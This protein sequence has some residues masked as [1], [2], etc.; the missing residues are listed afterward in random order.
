M[1]F[2]TLLFSCLALSGF[3]QLTNWY[4]EE[5][6][7]NGYFSISTDKAYSELLRG[8]TPKEVIVA[9]IDS[10]IDADHEDL[11]DVMWVN[12][13]EI[14]GNGTD[15]DGN[16]YIDDMH[17]WNFLGNAEGENVNQDTYEMTRL[18]AQYREKYGEMTSDS[19][20]SEKEKK[21]FGQYKEW[22]EKIKKE[23]SNA[24]SKL[25]EFDRTEKY[26]LDVVSSL[27]DHLSQDTLTTETLEELKLSGNAQLIVGAN[28]VESVSEQYGKIPTLSEL[29]RDI[30]FQF[31]MMRKDPIAK[32]YYQYNPD[33]DSRVIV[34]D[35]YDNLNER[36]Y[37]NNDVEGP[38]AFH[39]T[40]VAGIVAAQRDNNIG[41]NG[42]AGNVRIMSVRAVPDGDEHDKD[43]A[44]AIIYAVDN[45]AKVINMSFGK[46][47]SPEKEVV[48][49][50]VRYAEKNDVLLVHAAGN[51]STNN[52]VTPNFPNDTYKKGFGF[53]FF[54]KK[55]PKNWLEVGALSN[56]R[57]ANL[58][59]PFS[60]YGKN[61]ID[62]FSPGM[63]M[64]APVPNNGY[65]V[66]QGTS[67]AAPVVT[68]IAAVLRGYFP[69]LKAKEIKSILINSSLRSDK[70]VVV[71]GTNRKKLPFSEL[72][73]S[74]GAV[75]LYSAIKYAKRTYDSKAKSG[76]GNRG[77]ESKK[78]K[79]GK[80]NIAP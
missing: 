79:K 78:K 70:E 49:K 32:Y 80:P 71:P 43:V 21:E 16:G 25:D 53:L 55:Q 36:Y 75:N 10:G 51:G 17:G 22:G 23:R 3:G 34:N 29:K 73:V 68:G 11:K 76:S 63:F 45:G 60:N 15:D 27:D 5:A 74:G 59:A 18:Y 9:I 54:K 31:S 47:Y 67:M 77:K 69:N 41:T 13:G 14:P 38:D 57:D 48:D 4:D 42:I 30:G 62:L 66:L 7:V 20:L 52:D 26:L 33:F 44:N 40:H 1:R 35:N 6:D 64:L 65:Q 19:D 72:S 8:Q 58:V 56:A 50:A 12:E 37:G 2:L 61:E 24:K 46:G 28:I 39:G